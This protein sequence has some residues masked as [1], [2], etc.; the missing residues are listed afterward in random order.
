MAERRDCSGRPVAEAPYAPAVDAISS[1]QPIT[2][3][4]PATFV[5]RPAYLPRRCPASM[6]CLW[7]GVRNRT[8]HTDFG[9]VLDNNSLNRAPF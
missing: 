5:P 2:A 7:R 8:V 1:R 3:L 6:T 4:L 9:A